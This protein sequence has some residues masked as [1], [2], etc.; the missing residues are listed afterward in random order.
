MRII[1]RAEW[2]ARPPKYRY[3][4]STPTPR[5]WLHHAAG[6]ILPGDDSV[7][8]ADLRRIR[9]IQNY[10]MDKRGWSDIAYN[11]LVDPDGNIFEGRGAD[12]KG[13]HTYGENSVSHGICVMGNY[14]NQLVDSDLPDRLVE[15]VRFGYQQSW[16][17]LGFTGGHKDAPEAETSCP[18]RYLYRLLPEI[19]NTI[20]EDDMPFTEH[21]VAELR[22]LVASLDEVDSNGGFAKY[23]VL[24]VREA[25]SKPLHAPETSV[26]SHARSLAQKALEALQRIRD[27]I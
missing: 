19:N 5:L 24:L 8:D 13:G 23:A 11:F 17:P 18:G 12:I 14:D 15:F 26:D 2:G 3:N 10:H 9:S 16:W 20:K 4:L 1:T 25:R 22:R 6:A 7:S 27:A 21:E